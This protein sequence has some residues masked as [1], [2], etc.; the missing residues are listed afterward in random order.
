MFSDIAILAACY[1]IFG[2]IG[3][4]FCL[5]LRTYKYSILCSP[6]LGYSISGIIITIFYSLGIPIS[7]IFYLITAIGFVIF[8]GALLFFVAHKNNY[9]GRK[10]DIAIVAIIFIGWLLGVTLLMLPKWIGGIQFSIF[11]GNQWDQFN[12]ITSSLVY[13]KEQYGSVLHATGYEFLKNPLLPIA[14]FNINCRPTVMLLYSFVGQLYPK[15]MYETH[16]TFLIFFFLNA[17]TAIVFFLANILD[18]TNRKAISLSVLVS[19]SFVIG[20]WGQYILDINAWSQIASIPGLILLVAIF[21]IKI[22]PNIA[23]KN[24]REDSSNSKENVIQRTLRHAYCLIIESGDYIVF[25]L[26]FSSILF[27]YPENL[28]FH[29]VAIGIASLAALIMKYRL[30]NMCQLILCACIG[31]SI[32]LFYY[33]GTIGF[34]IGQLNLANSS[35][36]NWWAYFDRF[37]LGNDVI[38]AW[39]DA[40]SHAILQEP[41][42]KSFKSSFLVFPN[43]L[44]LLTLPVNILAGLL[45]IYFL[46]PMSEW[47]ISIRLLV[48]VLLTA[49]IF[50]VIYLN[51]KSAITSRQARV[52]FFSLFLVGMFTISLIL[53][54]KGQLWSAGK[55]I[56]LL[57]PYLMVFLFLPLFGKIGK[58]LSMPIVASIFLLCFQFL[59]GFA[60]PLAA[61][62]SSGIHYSSPPYPSIQSKEMKLE[63]DCNVTKLTP[64]IEGCSLLKINV[65]DVWL[66]HLLMIYAYSNDK[67]F[68]HENA[69]YTSYGV[70]REIGYQSVNKRADCTITVK[71]STND[72]KEAKAVK[73]QLIVIRNNQSSTP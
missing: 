20:F 62:H 70:G 15:L 36:V 12:Y 29:C 60:R 57:S 3:M 8:L 34:V 23:I 4:P 73:K 14:Q 26:L 21:I 10:P 68:Y 64:L 38:G 67:G 63:Y 35:S 16:Y 6:I 30:T 37:Y 5:L 51:I 48:F 44:Y 17:I 71:E 24:N 28:A 45:G 25:I 1:A 58:K 13:A 32:G 7:N 59:F 52:R 22:T 41:V 11:Q 53:L 43:C 55:G 18:I 50:C 72:R 56:S 61:R 2:S 27:I 46:T 66:Q 54:L 33:N 47:H 65:P 42:L 39:F 49:L 31:V 69:V 19:L 40:R 9:N